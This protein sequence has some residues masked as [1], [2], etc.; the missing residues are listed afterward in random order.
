[1][2]SAFSL[3]AR[4][5]VNLRGDFNIGNETFFENLEEKPVEEEQV[6]V[7]EEEAQVAVV[8]EDVEMKHEAKEEGEEGEEEE[9]G[10]VKDEIE[11]GETNEDSIPEVPKKEIKAIVEEK[12]EDLPSR[13]FT[14]LR[15]PS[16]ILP[17]A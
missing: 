12:R 9:E 7:E 2:A 15:F 10:V 4:S 5:G 17:S 8:E 16:L 1:M 14:S 6:V 13:Q 3:G 11:E